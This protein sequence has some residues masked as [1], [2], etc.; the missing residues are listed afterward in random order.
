MILIGIVKTYNLNFED[1]QSLQA[2]FNKQLS[3]NCI[4]GPAK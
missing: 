2:V 1:C 3:P 4:A